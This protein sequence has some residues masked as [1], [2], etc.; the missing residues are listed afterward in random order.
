MPTTTITFEVNDSR[1]RQGFDRLQKELNATERDLRG[2]Q[3]SADKTGDAVEKLGQTSQRTGERLRDVR[4]KFVRASGGADTFT[5]ALGGARGLLT[6]LGA[7]V[8][9]RELLQ[10]GAAS[11][12]A[13]GEMEGLKRAL[14]AIE[15]SNADQRLRAFNESA[16]PPGLNNTPQTE[17][18]SRTLAKLRAEAEET[19][20]V[21][22]NSV[23]RAAVTPN[24][25]A[26]LDASSAYY[27]AR[28]T[29]AQHALAAETAG[30]EK[31]QH[32][33]T[34]IFEL[35]RQQAGAEKALAAEQRALETDRARRVQIVT[36]TERQE[37]E[38][39]AAARIAAAA[40]ARVVEVQ[41]WRAAAA[42]GKTYAEQ[43][44]EIADAEARLAR[45]FPRGNPD[46]ATR[47]RLPT[48][49]ENLEARGPDPVQRDAEFDK[50]IAEAAKFAET[51]ETI[52]ADAAQ[53][54][55]EFV[56]ALRL[57][58]TEAEEKAVQQSLRR[59]TAAYRR[60]ANL[61]SNTFVNLA[62]GRVE[63]FQQVA[64][65]FIQQSLRIVARA[66]V[67]SEIQKRLDDQLTAAKLANSRKVAAAQGVGGAGSTGNLGGNLGGIGNLL[68]N[69][70][71]LGNIGSLL[72]GG[73][74]ALGASAL[75]FPTESKNLLQGIKQEIGGLLN[76]VA[77]IPGQTF[78][79]K[80]QVFLKIGD[81]EV[82]D[83]T[84]LQDELRAE[85]R[86]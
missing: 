26:A 33:Q 41:G 40:K 27:Q 64:T 12:R 7:A 8:A 17:N 72:S 55:G 52:R 29:Q 69:I 25:Q 57:Q 75:L 84:N 35:R 62:T 76:S 80:Q 10:F 81:N 58:Q 54:G 60:F 39:A 47:R 71:G 79:A 15:G 4:G 30:S 45:E 42:E 59:Q 61:V 68:G 18:V 6:G 5:K 28:I 38:R 14:Q 11:V 73:G 23:G 31:Y 2:T 66:Y 50:Q 56:T 67:E 20:R 3:Q 83:I 70:P 32:L 34:Q 85:D 77:D 48:F 16:K 51:L 21:L 37:R 53:K 19:R 65:A 9:A 49:A 63:R 22:T 78:G 82:R 43:L 46:D 86:V 13:A 1:A 74:A 44:R 24:F 36:G